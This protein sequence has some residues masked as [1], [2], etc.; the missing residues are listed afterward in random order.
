MAQHKPYLDGARPLCFAHRGGAALWP[1]NTLVALRGAIELGV[2]HLET[3]VHLTRDGELVVFHDAR[4]ERTTDGY[5][6]IR[7]FTL[8]ELQELDAGFRFSPDGK[9]RPWRGKG[10]RIPRLSE[11]FELD[12][13]VKLNVEMKQSGVG[14][15]RALWELIEQRSLHDR[16]LVAAAELGLGREF[17]KLARGRVA[18]SA[19]ALE[20]AELWAA[21][22]VG[23]GRWVPVDYDALQVPPSQY[24]LEVVTEQ[25]VELAHARGLHVHVWTIDDPNEM[26]RLRALGVDGLMSDRPDVLLETMG[27]P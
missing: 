12:P 22:R 23:V 27:A 19:S 5:G 16:I 9:T 18:T 2:T 6:P 7:D 26:R 17:R 21:G 15:P 1:E 10:L 20:V 11:A 25:F 4:L 13:R 8:S 24:G 14:L 3:D